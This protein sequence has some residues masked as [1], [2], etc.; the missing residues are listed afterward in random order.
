MELT[1]S[2]YN[3]FGH[4]CTLLASFADGHKKVNETVEIVRA[5]MI[6]QRIIATIAVVAGVLAIVIG[7]RV[8]RNQIT[9]RAS[10]AGV[11]ISFAKI[12]LKTNG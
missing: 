10:Q 12:Y 7:P 1:S 9:K 11:T 2:P 5:I 3:W 4:E 6:K 8:I